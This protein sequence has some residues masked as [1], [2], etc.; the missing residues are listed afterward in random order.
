MRWLGR[1]SVVGVFGLIAY[2]AWPLLDLK[3][4]ADAIDARDAGR[5]TELLDV[6]ELKRSIASQVARAHLKLT[7]PTRRL[8]P[9]ALN[10]ATNAGIV[11]ADSYVI[12]IVKSERLFDLLKPARIETFAGPNINPQAWAAPNLRNAGKL[13][14]A[15]EYRGRNFYVTLPLSAQAPQQF[16]LRLKLTEWKWKLAGIDLPEELQ[17]RLAREFGS[18]STP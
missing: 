2:A 3:R 7:N 5:F 11:L 1:L 13:L 17:L 8:S 16:R 6:N 14:S 10:M 12:E 4:I 9:L 18:K 15:A